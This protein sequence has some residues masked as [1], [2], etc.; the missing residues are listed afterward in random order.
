MTAGGIAAL[1]RPAA[2]GKGANRLGHRRTK[3]MR[4]VAVSQTERAGTLASLAHLDVSDGAA[5]NV[6]G[7]LWSRAMLFTSDAFAPIAP[8]G[9]AQKRETAFAMENGGRIEANLQILET[10]NTQS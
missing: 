5:L 4:F 3:R 9:C 2:P 6:K 7:E 10:T 1:R 8:S